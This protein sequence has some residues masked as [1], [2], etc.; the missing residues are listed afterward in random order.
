M[1]C[2]HCGAT[3]EENKNFCGNCGHQL[4]KPIAE[5]SSSPS[6]P[7]T[8][9]K[10]KWQLQKSET[11]TAPTGVPR[12]KFWTR[13]RPYVLFFLWFAM[14]TNLFTFVMF[15]ISRAQ[16]PQNFFS[17][18]AVGAICLGAM[19]AKKNELLGALLGFVV[20]AVVF[21]IAQGIVRIAT[22]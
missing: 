10:P 9:D 20:A 15:A 18:I 8:L 19:H 21:G 7:F 3:V 13:A 17:G 22:E 2:I 4:V 11:G 14:A 12:R 16:L 1:F 5:E 6:S